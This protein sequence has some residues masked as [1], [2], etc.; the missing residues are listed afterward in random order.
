[1]YNRSTRIAPAFVLAML[2]FAVYAAGASA[3]AS[4]TWVSGVGD[5]ANPCSRTA[6]CKTLAGAISKTAVGG[7]I[8]ALDPGGF[9][10]VTIT[11]S[12]TIDGNGFGSVLNSGSNGI[13]VNAGTAGEV[14]IRNL[15]IAGASTGGTCP[16]Y[17]GLSAVKILAASSVRLDNVAINNQSIG[18]ETPA[19]G[20]SPDVYMDLTLNN[21]GIVNTCT[22]GIS[23]APAAGHP[24]RSTIRNSSISNANTALAIFTGGEVWSSQ[25]SYSLNNTGVDVS[26]GGKF[27]DLGGSFAAGNADGKGLPGTDLPVTPAVSYCTVPRTTGK[28]KSAAASAFTAAGCK[29]GRST[30]KKVQKRSSR[31]KVIAQSIPAGTQVRTGTTVALTI[32]R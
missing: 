31:G 24:V 7:E 11:K 3:Q 32:G 30:Y 12:I 19:T 25:T 8:D 26:G 2:V 27:T 29:L 14:I 1:M 22:A 5:D 10:A 21:V 20:T 4:R 13:I 28:T 16:S 23:I 6:P 17:G 9:G 18:I 15:S